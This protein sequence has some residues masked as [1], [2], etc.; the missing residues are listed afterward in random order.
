MNRE[1]LITTAVITSVV[2]AALV[3]LASFGLALDAGQTQAIIGFITVVAPLVLAYVARKHVTPVSDP[4]DSN[5]SP[6][7][8]ESDAAE[9]FEPAED[10]TE[11][12]DDAEKTD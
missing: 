5:G 1:P 3:L 9:E 11:L 7:A 6:L 8:P 2:S 10:G 4:K 12:V